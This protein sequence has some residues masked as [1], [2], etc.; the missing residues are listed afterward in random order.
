MGQLQPINRA[1]ELDRKARLEGWP[2]RCDA[3]LEFERAELNELRE[4]WRAL[5]A[6]KTAPSRTDFDARTLKPYLRNIMIIE[7]VFIGP[8]RWRYRT[9]L[10]G[11]A[12]ADMIGDPTGKFLEEQLPLE[13]V[14][15]WTSV[16][17]ATL[18]GGRPLRLVANF[19]LPQLVFLR[20]EAFVA[21][22]ADR[23][24]KLTLVFGCIY[25]GPKPANR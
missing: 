8:E 7:R 6:G 16:Y 15:R 1:W 18:D 5:A 17:D 20:G 2:F 4:L 3:M 19:E 11:T 13:L 24:G 12:V 14:P 23:E 10:A 21:P 22:L 25:F 9:R